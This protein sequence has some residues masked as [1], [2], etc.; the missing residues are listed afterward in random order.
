MK[1]IL[2]AVRPGSTHKGVKGKMS[3]NLKLVLW[4]CSG[5]MAKLR[6]EANSLCLSERESMYD[7]MS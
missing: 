7:G 6:D 1:T 4:Y 2:V 5:G 3:A